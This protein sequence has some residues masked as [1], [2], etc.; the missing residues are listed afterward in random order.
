MFKIAFSSLLAMAV[1]FAPPAHAAFT[2][3]QKTYTYQAGEADSKLTCRTVALE[4]VKRL[5][6][7]ELGTYIV[8]KTEIKNTDITK[9]E[10]TTLTAGIVSAEI[11]EE[12][13]DGATY[14][15]KVE[16]N[17]DPDEVAKA[18]KNLREDDQTVKEL[19][20]AQAEARAASAEIEKLRNELAAMK[21][22]EAAL[23][24]QQ[25]LLASAEKQPETKKTEIKQAAEEKPS[26][27]AKKTEIE[28]AAPAAA[29]FS[30]AEKKYKKRINELEAANLF[31]K[32]HAMREARKYAAAVEVFNRV[33]ELEPGNARA[34]AQRGASYRGLLK[35]KLA[36]ADF[37]KAIELRP[38][39]GRAYTGLALTLKDA[40]KGRDF[41]KLLRKAASHGDKKAIRI[42]E[43]MEQKRGH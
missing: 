17:V 31:Q 22:N 42:L 2:T 30:E 6:L 8:S 35:Y 27:D 5:M 4:Q 9:D 43:K 38:G 16:L 39:F 34:Y 15:I 36:I 3:F 37:K 19:Q 20:E 23:K 7:E 10:V 12:K 41:E 11:K 13:W 28:S 29:R 40:G 21:A 1:V 14:V 33:I 18:V 32:G 24:Q 25:A 26:A